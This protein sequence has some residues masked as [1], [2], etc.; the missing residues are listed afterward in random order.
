ML[1]EILFVFTGSD[2]SF[3]S[4]SRDLKKAIYEALGGLDRE[5]VKQISVNKLDVERNR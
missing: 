1:I 5:K 4:F 3:S 2:F